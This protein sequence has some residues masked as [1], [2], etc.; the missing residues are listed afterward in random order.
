MGVTVGGSLGAED[1]LK[2]FVLLYADDTIPV[3]DSAVGLQ[4]A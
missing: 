1:Y 4:K 3:F 2:L